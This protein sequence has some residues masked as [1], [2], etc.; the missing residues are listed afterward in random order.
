MKE[1]LNFKK[2]TGLIG[3]ILF[4]FSIM[5]APEIGTVNASDPDPSAPCNPPCQGWVYSC[6][7]KCGQN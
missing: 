3:A 4:A 1:K 6:G 5:V 2:I 7:M